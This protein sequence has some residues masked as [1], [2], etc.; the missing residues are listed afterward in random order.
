MSVKKYGQL[1]A[2]SLGDAGMTKKQAGRLADVG[3][4][5]K[6][7]LAK[8]GLNVQKFNRRAMR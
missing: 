4:A 2:G 5:A 7:W 3:K 6:A 8:R 1:N